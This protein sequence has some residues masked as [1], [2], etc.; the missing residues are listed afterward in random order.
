M[1]R[2]Y[3]YDNMK[4]ILILFVIFGHLLEYIK[5]DI[6]EN[7]YRIIYTFHMPVF[8][9]I[10][11]YF[12]KYN[13][14]KIVF[15]LLI[16][17]F[18]LQT[19][20]LIF[21]S[22]IISSSDIVIQY[23]TPYWLLWFILTLLFYYLLI[24]LIDTKNNVNK[25]FF[26]VSIIFLSLFISYTKNIGYYASLHRFFTFFPYF[27]LGYYYKNSN[28]KDII[29][30]KNMRI[31]ICILASIIVIA[32]SIYIIFTK[33]YTKWV[34]YGSYNYESAYYNLGMK[35]FLLFLGLAW[36]LFFITLFPRKK[37]PII[38]Y[39]GSNTFY[40]FILHGF[41]IKYLGKLNIFTYSE[42]L[43]IIYALGISITLI[44]LLGNI[45]IKL[46]CRYILNYQWIYDLFIIFKN[47]FVNKYRER[48]G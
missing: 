8:I 21:D 14:K 20:Y 33:E 30:K 12:A 45:L 23:V 37:I 26:I 32:S 38:S 25:L 46:I 24:P 1:E 35:L 27:V 36:I 9:F 44:I 47:N 18:I 29:N 7:I 6:S 41:F 39:L 22:K 28:I 19:I 5:G 10:S 17:Y 31:I 13:R 3:Q 43:N 15:Q 42:G 4:F 48:R 2:E 11:G 34:L 16:P 40:I